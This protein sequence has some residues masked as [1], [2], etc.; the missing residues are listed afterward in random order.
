MTRILLITGGTSAGS[1]HTAALRTAARSAPAGLTAVLYDGLRTLPAFVPGEQ[2]AP[3]P[4]ARLRDEVGAAQAVLFST[5]EYAG[6]LPGSLKNLLDWLVDGGDLNGKP[7]AWLSVA[8]PGQD[9]SALTALQTALSFGNARLL[10]PAC[11]RVPLDPAAV[12]AAGLVTDPQLHRAAQDILRALV[13]SAAA[14][15][16]RAQPSWQ[17]YSSVFPVVMRRDAGTPRG[18]RPPA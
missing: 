1:L 13:Q 8:A 18:W 14:P 6:S 5:P 4:V 17:A 16:P 15:R 2:P 3:E 11:I 10:R 9:E 7:A 12:D